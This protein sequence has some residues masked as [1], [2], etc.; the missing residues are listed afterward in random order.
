MKKRAT[1][2]ATLVAA[3]S[4]AGATTVTAHA[5]PALHSHHDMEQV[6]RVA[7]VRLHALLET[8]SSAE[9]GTAIHTSGWGQP[10]H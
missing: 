3:A 9:H 10:V 6:S 2:L 7:S 5:F 4:L 8:P 1:A